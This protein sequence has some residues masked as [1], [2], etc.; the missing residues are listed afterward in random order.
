MRRDRPSCPKY[1][2]YGLRF[3]GFSGYSVVA[4][5]M[6]YTRM[7]K[8]FLNSYFLKMERIIGRKSCSLLCV[9]QGVR[10]GGSEHR[11]GK[12]SAA[13]GLLWRSRE[14]RHI[15]GYFRNSWLIYQL[16]APASG[17]PPPGRGCYGRDTRSRE[18]RG[19][20][21]IPHLTPKKPD[22]GSVSLVF[23]GITRFRRKQCPPGW[24]SLF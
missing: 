17:N 21:V 2:R 14:I 11:S 13:G 20:P 24:K 10:E 18:L 15:F 12:R 9:W 8:S 3:P 19:V 23:P 1:A 16:Y 4:W 6:V 7:E 5:E 22:T